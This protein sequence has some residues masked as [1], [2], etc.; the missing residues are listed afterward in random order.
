MITVSTQAYIKWVRVLTAIQ[1][2]KPLY[3]T[4][5]VFVSIMWDVW[6]YVYAEPLSQLTPDL[7][8]HKYC[9][10]QYTQYTLSAHDNLV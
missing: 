2:K 3:I 10:D 6:M 9:V 4:F 5:C 7:S 8:R 1:N